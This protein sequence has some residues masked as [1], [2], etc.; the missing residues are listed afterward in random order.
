MAVE[1]GMHV[2]SS[3]P[4]EA[5]ARLPFA[6]LVDLFGDLLD[7]IQPDLPPPQ[8]FALDVALLRTTVVDQHPEPLAISLA[9]LE[10]VREAAARAPLA[11]G[12]D[13][14]PWLD[15]SSASVLEFVFR[16]LETEPVVVV[17]GQRTAGAGSGMPPLIGAMAAERVTTLRLAPLSAAHTEQLLAETLNLHLAPSTMKRLHRTSGGNPF[18]AVEIARALQRRGL[19][20]VVGELPLPDTLRGLVRD[21]LDALSDEASA[22]VVHASALSQPATRTIVAAVGDETARAGLADATAAGVLTEDAGL[23]RFSHPLLAAEAYAGLDGAQRRDLHRRLATVVTE[24]EEHARHIALGVD[25][26]DGPDEE[27]ALTLEHAAERAHARGAPDAAADFA[28]RAVSLSGLEGPGRHRR[29]VAAA[30]YRVLAGEPERAR[31]L[32]EAA[33]IATPEGD[34]RAQILVRL[35]QAE[36]LMGDWIAAE[37][38][39]DTALGEVSDDIA[40]RIEIKLALAGRSFITGREWEAG[41]QHVADAMRLADELG[42]PRVIAGTIGH[43][44][45]WLRATNRDLPS[46]LQERVAELEPWTGHLRALDHP[47]FDLSAIAWADGDARTFREKHLS[48]VAR[49]ERTGDYSSLPFLLPNLIRSDLVDGRRDDA[50]NRLDA[51]ERMAH[52]TGQRTAVANVLTWRTLLLARVGL[53]DEAWDAGRR[54]LQLIAETGFRLGEPIV[55]E[56]LALLELSRRDPARA[57]QVMEGFAQP[58]DSTV[59]GASVWTTPVMIEVLIALGRLRDAQSALAQLEGGSS[60]RWVQSSKPQIIRAR[61]LVAAAIGDIPAGTE[62][63]E[64]AKDASRLRGDRWEVARTQFAAGEIHRRAR[65]RAMAGGALAEAA[66]LFEDLGAALWLVRAREE[67]ERIGAGRNDEGGLTVTQLQV[68]QLAASGMTNKEIANRLFMSV[69]TVEAHL[70]AAYRALDIGSRRDLAAALGQIPDTMR[71]SDPEVRDSASG[72]AAET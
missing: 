58:V 8:R 53:G 50:V 54:A 21:R 63:I 39:W 5:E 65:R 43:Y 6:G 34:S 3:R 47:D 2:V 9:V 30:Q 42:D 31:D 4:T 67:L 59:W 70:S 1:S 33:L 55:R 49:A 38:R 37:E 23:V 10:L 15:Q 22:V 48:L 7:D 66:Q 61:A 20:R 32:L 25:G 45:A 69:H 35:G 51:G 18:Y 40:L 11:I 17:A 24:P 62:L 72:A 36:S 60:A 16:R 71:D 52:A 68:A 12:I 57:L 27:I 56:E 29:L 14:V 19:T 26:A 44:A 41:A 28:D 64:A 46:G 13:D